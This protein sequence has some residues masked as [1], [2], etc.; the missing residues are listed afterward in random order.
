MHL[1]SLPWK[2]GGGLEWKHSYIY[3]ELDTTNS[4]CF[5]DLGS[6]HWESAAGVRN[7]HGDG[8]HA[9]SSDGG[10]DVRG[11]WCPGRSG[12]RAQAS[13][14]G[15]LVHECVAHQRA[16]GERKGADEIKLVRI[17]RV[18]AASVMPSVGGEVR[19]L[20][21]EAAAV[22]TPVGERRLGEERLTSGVEVAEFWPTDGGQA[23]A[24]VFMGVRFGDEGG[25]TTVEGAPAWHPGTRGLLLP[26]RGGGACRGEG[27]RGGGG[28][29]GS[30]G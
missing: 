7:L 30:R 8:V 15:L 11:G 22:A 13:G 26:V 9:V 1:V 19:V 2:D 6:S 24:S 18:T 5:Q 28:M 4:C 12:G 3:N 16:H 17:R 20:G 23:A 27:A 14:T 21:R 25:T 10:G 29:R